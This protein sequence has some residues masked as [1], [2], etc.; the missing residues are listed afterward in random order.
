M[1]HSFKSH[2]FESNPLYCSHCYVFMNIHTMC[3]QVREV[4]KMNT[5]RIPPPLGTHPIPDNN[6]I[7]KWLEKMYY[8][9]VVSHR[10]PRLVLAL[11]LNYFDLLL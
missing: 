11:P 8:K 10:L 5:P 6:K 1:D 3:S 7:V 2:N 9:Q 4:E